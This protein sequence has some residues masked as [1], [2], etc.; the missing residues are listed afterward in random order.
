SRVQ[1]AVLRVYGD[2]LIN[3]PGIPEDVRTFVASGL[4]TQIAA[5]PTTSPIKPRMAQAMR[6]SLPGNPIVPTYLHDID[7]DTGERGFIRGN[8]TTVQKLVYVVM[9][10]HE[11]RS[12]VDFDNA[13]RFGERLY[14]D[15]RY[16]DGG[17]PDVAV[18]VWMRGRP[19]SDP[20]ER[21]LL[22]RH[23]IAVANA[24]YE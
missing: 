3:S 19:D 11:P 22:L 12:A 5:E 6:E 21:G 23:D 1:L 18:V 14:D 7:V 4:L 16:V 20:S 24:L 17:E 2:M 15:M 9:P 13:R 8:P 10:Q